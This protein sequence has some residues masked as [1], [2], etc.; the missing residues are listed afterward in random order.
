MENHII[1]KKLLPFI[2]KARDGDDTLSFVEIILEFAEVNAIDIQLVQEAIQEDTYFK[3]LLMND[4][5][6]KKII[7]TDKDGLDEW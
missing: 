1:M 6:A 3:E 7:K 5:V 4:C 2:T